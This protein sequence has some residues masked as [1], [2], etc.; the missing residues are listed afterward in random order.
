MDYDII[1]QVYEEIIGIVNDYTRRKN[2]EYEV[3][4]K[5]SFSLLG[6]Y[7]VFGTEIFSKLNVLL[8]SVNIYECISEEDYRERAFEVAPRLR[9]NQNVFRY[10][11]ITIW[12]YKYDDEKNFLGGIPNVIYMKEELTIDNVLSIVHELSHGLEGVSASIISEDE[13]TVFVNQGFTCIGINKETN[14]FRANDSGFIELMAISLENR[15]LNALLKLEAKKITSPLLKEFLEEI[16]TYKG[17]NVMT[18]SYDRL[19]VTFKD[20]IDNDAFYNLVKKYFY[21][22]DEE[23]FK[24]EYESYDSRLN[25]RTLKSAAQF[26]ASDLED[27]STVLYYSEIIMKHAQLFGKATDFE[28]DKK[29]LILV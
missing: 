12:D 19:N 17:K 26:L 29:L 2:C 4:R 25:Y 24:V 22:N 6:Y 16:K 9:E 10:N 1:N 14:R 18:K 3:A 7:L 13:N 11:P 20:F 23:G 21:E 15:V 5:L 27:I 8:D 28:P